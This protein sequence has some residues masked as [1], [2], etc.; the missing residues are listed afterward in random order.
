MN[1][2]RREELREFYEKK[3]ENLKKDLEKCTD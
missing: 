3:L 2:K 1:K